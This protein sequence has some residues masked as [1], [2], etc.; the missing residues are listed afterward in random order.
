MQ[1]FIATILAKLYVY[2]IEYGE[3]GY[4]LLGM[5]TG[6]AKTIIKEF[7]ILAGYNKRMEF[8]N[9]G[10]V[11]SYIKQDPELRENKTLQKLVKQ[12]KWE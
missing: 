5:K 2:H 1:F 6:A 9:S 12:F 4:D 7:Q 8:L 11:V 10:N 3:V